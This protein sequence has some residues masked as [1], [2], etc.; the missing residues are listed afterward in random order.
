M[1]NFVVDQRGSFT[2]LSAVS[3]MILLVVAG[4]A[5]DFN[6]MTSAKNKLQ[7][8]ADMAALAG[9]SIARSNEPEMQATALKTLQDNI[10]LI[11][12]LALSGTPDINI[13]PS[14]KEITVTANTNY[15]MMFGNLL[16]I[17]TMTITASSTSGYAIESVNPF[18]VYLVLDVSGSMSWNSSD[19]QVKIETL[20]TAVDDMFYTLYSTSESPSLLVSTIRTGFS[21]YNTVLGPTRDM[22]SGYSATVNQVNTLVAAG[23]TNS[24]PGFQFAYDQIKDEMDEVSNLAPYIVFMTD[25]DNNDPA[26]DVTTTALCDQARLDN[27]TVFTVAFEAPANGQ[28]LLQ[29][30]ATVPAKAYNSTNAAALNAAFVDIGREISQSVVRLK[31]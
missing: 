29:A 15:K 10:E 23:G 27:I 18:A 21:S 22:S 5:Y 31:R 14:A 1:K 2:M 28:A 20:K 26:F 13:D 11:P 12:N 17:D 7:D 30:C 19:G 6:A 9:A 25:G 4:V 8:S 24:T 16:G 3:L